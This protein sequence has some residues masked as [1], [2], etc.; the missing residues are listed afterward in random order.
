MGEFTNSRLSNI[1][2]VMTLLVMTITAVLLIYY[3]FKN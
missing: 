1:L 3:Q 2:G